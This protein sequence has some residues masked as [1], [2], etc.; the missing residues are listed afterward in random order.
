M[1]NLLQTGLTGRTKDMF[2][3]SSRLKNASS[4]R[5]KS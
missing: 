2:E 1:I 3:N 4:E 5:E